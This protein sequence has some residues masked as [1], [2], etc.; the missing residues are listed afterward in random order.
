MTKG[1]LR[2]V[3]K[4][5][6]FTL[7]CITLLFLTAQVPVDSAPTETLATSSSVTA[8]PSPTPSAQPPSAQPNFLEDFWVANR[9]TIILA[10]ITTIL[11]GV[12]LRQLAK[13]IVTGVKRGLA[14]L[15]S[16]FS[17]WVIFRR[18]L[19]QNYVAVLDEDTQ[20][21]QFS[22]SRPIDMEQFYIRVQVTHLPAF[23]M[24]V[25]S[26]QSDWQES[27]IRRRHQQK[28]EPRE[29]LVR[30]ERVVVIG[31]PGAGKTTLLRYLTYLYGHDKVSEEHRPVVGRHSRQLAIEGSQK[32][33]QE[34]VSGVG[35]ERFYIHRTLEPNRSSYEG[36]KLG[37][38]VPVYIALTELRN[39]VDLE[40]YLPV[41]FVQHNY[42][43][44]TQFIRSKLERGE[45]I[46]LFDGLD[47]IDEPNTLSHIVTVIDEFAARYSNQQYHNWIV[48]TSRPHTYQQFVHT[49]NFQVVELL[50]FEPQQVRDFVVNWFA[51][52]PERAE[53][54]WKTIS[55]QSSLWEIA[56]NPLMLTLIVESFDQRN[57]L[58]TNGQFDLYN[59]IVNVRF[60]GWDNI[61]SA[62][63]DFRFSQPI[64]ERF[65]RKLALELNVSASTLL[66]ERELLERAQTFLLAG[67]YADPTE[68]D[69][70]HGTLAR[71]FVW[72]IAVGSGLLQQKSISSYDF[73][74]KTLR[75]Y[76][77]ALELSN[78]PDGLLQLLAHLQGSPL[79]RWEMVA[80]FYAGST[81]DAAPLILALSRTNRTLSN[82]GL[83]LAARCLHN[84]TNV[85]NRSALRD[86]LCDALFA[87]LPGSGEAMRKEALSLIRALAPDRLEAYVSMLILGTAT[88]RLQLAADL[89]PDIPSLEL[90]E[91]MLRELGLSLAFGDETLRAQAAAL[92]VV[93]NEDEAIAPLLTTL[94]ATERDARILAIVGLA[95]LG[96]IEPVVLEAL[97][98]VMRED[99][100]P[101][102]RL[103]ARDALLR[104]GR[105]SELGMI[106]VPAG[107]FLMGTSMDQVNYLNS[108]Y[109]WDIGWYASEIPQR[110]VD[111]EEFYIDKHLV[112]N[113]SFAAFVADTGY[114]TTAEQVGYG[115]MK[116]GGKGEVGTV[117]SIN[118][119]H[120]RGPNST[121]EEIPE[122]PVVLL[123]WYDTMAYCQ[124]VG[125]TLPTEVQW[126]K[127]ARGTDGR[128][129][130]WGNVWDDGYCNAASF[131]ATRSLIKHD[132]WFDWWT[133][134]DQTRYGPP[135]TPAGQFA[136]GASP[137][138]VL[139][140]AGNV[141]ER[142][143][144][145]YRPYPGT[146]DR[147]ENYG[148]KLHVLRGGAWHHH[149]S[150]VRCAAR[151]YA[152]P[153]FCTVHDGFRCVVNI[154]FQT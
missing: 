143:L 6:G 126:E 80:L 133:R 104:L 100:D 107:E 68:T 25:D 52:E 90:Q 24:E 77:A 142:T 60:W 35:Q 27:W 47:E 69:P 88:N 31:E 41:Y 9:A 122:H 33:D 14:W 10:L 76:F 45:M 108:L 95:K 114:Q 11:I 121:W 109:G 110:Q 2:T 87:A 112:T 97:R 99:Q 153:L 56:R 43:N 34:P 79:D 71:R 38:R 127:A 140:C 123:S 141:C 18:R 105:A 3:L 16:T 102:L 37:N 40:S 8:Q 44:A 23:M 131:Q 137:Y 146:A 103:K 49:L 63:R 139:D 30:Y 138:G 75:E 92:M 15:T 53:R 101:V 145:W 85:Q 136:Q 94:D 65:L 134:F 54:L 129:W 93:A 50:D 118:W 29:A 111:L 19:Y 84:A 125:K 74:H 46:L 7:V 51:K 106:L 67:N 135:T 13:A 28:I 58:A 117:Q 57:E 149:P 154:D 124:W 64:K 89:M 152:H 86:E 144:D 1:S 55:G 113:A 4:H 130:P 147:S 20:K 98:R 32:Q 150:L 26:K 91:L 42:P 66:S 116:L 115:W 119:A 132:D 72:E 78:I 59:Q 128:I 36:W 151:D 83:L 73:S 62:R 82:R 96:R 17:D 5:L 48:I 39:I 61:R 12:F 120:P 148:E 21:W 70:N 22:Y 81:I